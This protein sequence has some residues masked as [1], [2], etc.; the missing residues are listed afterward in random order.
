MPAT[1]NGTQPHPGMTPR[2]VFAL[3]ALAGLTAA[4]IFNPATVAQMAYR[5]ADAMLAEQAK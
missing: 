3:A 5:I 4:H 2:D 1:L